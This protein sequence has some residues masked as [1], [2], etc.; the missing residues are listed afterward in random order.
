MTNYKTIH[1]LSKDAHRAA[2]GTLAFVAE[3]GGELYIKARNGWRKVQVRQLLYPDLMRRRWKTSSEADSVFFQL[4]ELIS[5]GPPTSAA[6]QSLSRSGEW[7][8]PQRVHSQV[9]TLLST[10][11]PNVCDKTLLISLVYTKE[12]VSGNNKIKYLLPNRSFL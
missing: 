8:K 11:L 3:R 5:P 12:K 4:G 10:I 7:N 9:Q 6:S 1:A 2:E